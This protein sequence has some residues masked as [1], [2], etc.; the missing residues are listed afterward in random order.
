MKRRAVRPGGATVKLC[1]ATAGPWPLERAPRGHLR[2]AIDLRAVCSSLEAAPAS[3]ERAADFQGC[4][5]KAHPWPSVQWHET[6]AMSGP[7]RG[8]DPPPA[9]ARRPLFFGGR[10]PRGSRN[11]GSLASFSAVPLLL[12]CLVSASDHARPSD[13]NR[14][15]PP[16]KQL[17]FVLIAIVS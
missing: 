15:G 11:P 6:C 7:I 13:R 16:P 5:R 9:R 12:R 4:T 10:V 2:L 1:R 3:S 8:P 14:L 17:R